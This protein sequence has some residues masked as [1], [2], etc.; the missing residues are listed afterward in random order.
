[1]HAR[2]IVFYIVWMSMKTLRNALFIDS[3]DSIIEKMVVMTKT[4]T[5][6]MVGLKKVFSYFSVI[7]HL[8]RWFA[9]KKEAGL[10]LCQKHIQDARLIRCLANTTRWQNIN[11]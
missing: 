5:E 1:M 10:L 2:M 4:T 8:K 3:I 11:L 9:K 7:S 6:E